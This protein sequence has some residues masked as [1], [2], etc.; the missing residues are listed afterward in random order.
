R[1]IADMNLLEL[2]GERTWLEMDARL[3]PTVQS[4][5]DKYLF[6]E[7]VKLANRMESLHEMAI[8]GPIAAEVLRKTIDAGEVPNDQGCCAVRMLGQEVIAW[9]DVPCGVP[10]YFLVV[11]SESAAAIWDHLIATCGNPG[12]S[13]AA[14][15]VGKRMLRPIGWAAF[16]TTRIEAGRPL[17]GI[18]FDENFLPAETAQ[19]GRAVS[20]TK[21]CYPGQ[22]IVARM[23]ARQQIARQ[24]VG[25]RIDGDALPIAGTHLYDEHDNQVGGITS[26]TVSPILSNAMI[27]LG[28]LKRPFFNVDTVVRVP[29]EGAMRTAKI[30]QLPF[31]R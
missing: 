22:E 30:V 2:G 10:G 5:L 15:N 23:H 3:I 24:I 9:Q 14:I 1:I 13:G 7:Q 6:A 31:A 27:C 20:F 17:F 26:S 11:P 8:H 12:V 28:V 25:I 19:L 4:A 16:N 21:G 29:A 18:D